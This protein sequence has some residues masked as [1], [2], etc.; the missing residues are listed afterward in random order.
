[1]NPV[2][3]GP[4]VLGAALSPGA[5][6]LAHGS[7]D[8]AWSMSLHAIAAR[9]RASRP[10]HPTTLA[11]L[12]LQEPDLSQACTDLIQQGVT[13]LTVIPMFL[14]LGRHLRED[15]PERVGRVRRAHPGVMI[16]L[17]ESMGESEMVRDAIATWI[18]RLG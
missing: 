4:D 5:V 13:Q 11:F 9:L 17:A 2:S 15:I 18:A 6:L 1:M 12:E 10:G 3:T 16:E 14:G 7:R 8:P